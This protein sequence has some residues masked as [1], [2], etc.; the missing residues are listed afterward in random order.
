[1]AP[2][3]HMACIRLET[4]HLQPFNDITILPSANHTTS[5][6]HNYGKWLKGKLKRENNQLVSDTD[7]LKLSHGI[8]SKPT[9]SEKKFNWLVPLPS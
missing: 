3:D 9:E 2:I 8:N 6:V 1:M 5:S 4:E 7:Q